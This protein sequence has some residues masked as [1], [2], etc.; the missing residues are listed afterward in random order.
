[1]STPLDVLA[2]PIVLSAPKRLVWSA[3]NGHIPFGM[4]LVEL[5]APRLLVELGTH[6]GASY[7]AFCQAISEL[8]LKTKAVAVDTWLGDEH[9]G[10]YGNDV[11]ADLR[12]HHDSLYG[13]FSTLLQCTFDEAA[14]IFQPDSIDL[15][16]IDGL[17]TYEAVRHD[18]ETWVPKMSNRGV[19]LFHD[20]AV[21]Q[22]GFGVRQFWAETKSRYPYFEMFHSSGLGILIV[23]EQARVLLGSILECSDGD[24]SVIRQLFEELGSRLELRVEKERLNESLHAQRDISERMER[25]LVDFYKLAHNPLVR[26]ARGAQRYGTIG[27]FREGARRLTTAK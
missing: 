2:H 5:L 10:V 4:L 26:L 7:C 6:S 27:V 24:K 17:H 25:E 12:K 13:S 3:W 21:T 18:F 11:L 1:M 23:G 14:L 22:S 15:L 16:H 8:G 9:S 19:I 20:T